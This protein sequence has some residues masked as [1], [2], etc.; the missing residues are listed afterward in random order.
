MPR[1]FLEVAYIG[2][3]YSGFQIQQNAKTIQSEVENAIKVIQRKHVALTG[4]SRT[5]AGVHAYQNFFHFDMDEI[6]P[7]NSVYKF[8]A[9]LPPQIVINNLITVK[10]TAHCRFDAISRDYKYCIYQQKNPFI[11]D[12]AF[13]YPYKID[14]ESLNMAAALLFNYND[15]TS[16]S[17]RNTQAKTFRCQIFESMWEAKG[18]GYIYSVRSNRFLRGMVRALTATM[19]QVGRGKLSISDFKRI[20]ISKDCTMAS[21]AVPAHGLFLKRVNYPPDYFK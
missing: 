1:F 12:R 15:F 21:F 17:K 18:A 10:D 14:L 7:S 5:D 19:L 16:F 20:I 11:Q 9:V 4:S 3:G 2:T 8:N 6:L 13:Y